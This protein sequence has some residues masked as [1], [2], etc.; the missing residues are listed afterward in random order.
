MD[1]RAMVQPLLSGHE[2]F[3][4]VLCRRLS[5]RFHSWRMLV[6]L[7]P[8]AFVADASLI[9]SLEKQSTPIL[10]SE[11]RVLF[12]QGDSS[13]GLYILQS[14]AATLTMR[15]ATGKEVISSRA[16]AGSLLGLPGLIGNEPYTLTAVA[17][18]GAQISFLAR[19]EFTDLISA[20]PML[21][22]KI[23]QVLAA[24]VRSARSAILQQEAPQVHR[25]R[26][27]TTARHP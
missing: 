21:A 4:C 23:L 22:L 17:H 27:L 1:S 25:T 3:I 18:A 7:D 15:S 20:D 6:N 12:R 13:I 19:E 26:R 2:S 24:E 10:C 5:F 9:Q 16:A 14:G 11:D 8:S